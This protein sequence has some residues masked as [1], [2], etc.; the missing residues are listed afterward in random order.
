[1]A[2]TNT[3][4]SERPPG[5]TV[6][7]FL[8]SCF[9]LLGYIALVLFSIFGVAMIDIGTEGNI[10]MI[11][12]LLLATIFTFLYQVL[13]YGVYKLNSFAYYMFIALTIFTIIINLFNLNVL[14][15]IIQVSTV[16]YLLLIPEHFQTNF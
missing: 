9:S 11:G 4:N 12:I 6:I 1:M 2:N 3:T 7:V 16:F 13:L 10:I 8:N 5:V 14:G 15:I